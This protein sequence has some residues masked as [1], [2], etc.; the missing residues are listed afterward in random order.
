MDR[1]TRGLLAGIIGGI[2]M[3]VWNL[4]D[5]YLFHITTIR[6][7]DW[8]SVLTTWERSTSA[9]Q[10]IIDLVLQ[11]IIWDGFLGIV[12]SHLI[13]S[14]T[15]KLVI[16]KSVIYGL[17]LWFFFKIVVNFCRVPFLSGKQSFPGRM[18]NVIAVIIWGLVLGIVLKALDKE[19]HQAV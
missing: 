2:A 1:T 16:Y 8:F 7:I 6:F 18:S 11:I 14:T 4:A 17:L 3:N 12:F 5:Y 10:T 13:R 9:L 19:P 15:S